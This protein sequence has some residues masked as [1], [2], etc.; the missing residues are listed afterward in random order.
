MDDFDARAATWDDDPAKRVSAADVAAA[1]RRRLPLDPALRVIEFGA[2][3]GLLSRELMDEVGPVVLTDAAPGMVEVSRQR[4]AELGREATMSAVV[5][6]PTG[7][8]QPALE[9]ADVIW[10][11]L[12]LH[13]VHDVDR[14]LTGLRDLLAPGGW[15]AIADLDHD[16]DG[17]FHRERPGFDGHHGFDREA[18]TAALTR[19][20]FD[21]VDIDTAAVI[22]KE[23]DGRT[24]DFPVF[25]ALAR[26]P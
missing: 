15:L 24:R 13:H 25:L 18:L 17:G 21:S 22:T 23:V 2:G 19:A 8:D 3:T 1:I 12:A 4:I 26:R 6:D 7:D 10:S 20:G 14:A 5:L 16:A 9:P 11:S